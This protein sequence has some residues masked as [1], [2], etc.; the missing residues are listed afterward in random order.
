MTVTAPPPGTAAQNPAYRSPRWRSLP[1]DR[2]AVRARAAPCRRSPARAGARRGRPSV[3]VGPEDPRRR[4]GVADR[5]RALHVAQRHRQGAVRE[6]AVDVVGPLA[7][8]VDGRDAAERAALDPRGRAGTAPG[9]GATVGSAKAMGS[10]SSMRSAG[11]V[12]RRSLA[13]RVNAGARRRRYCPARADRPAGA[14][15]ARRPPTA[16]IPV[17]GAASPPT[18][19]PSRIPRF[20]LTGTSSGV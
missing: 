8:P 14:R 13:P 19:A 18:T 3:L 20:P 5:E 10:T 4:A 1:A 17:G 11:R 16:A 7:T 15:R 6:E 2:V 12:R 9:V